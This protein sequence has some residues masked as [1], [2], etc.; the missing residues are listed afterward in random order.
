MALLRLARP[1]P[2][3]KYD[4]AT[5]VPRRRRCGSVAVLAG[6]VAGVRA[7][8]ELLGDGAIAL[9]DGDLSQLLLLGELLRLGHSV[10]LVVYEHLAIA[11]LLL[12]LPPV[13]VRRDV[14]AHTRSHLHSS[15]LS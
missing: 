12:D 3:P 13:H 1:R 6:D 9:V 5:V 8:G 7:V 10:V 11:A 4:A 2:Q 14:V 15:F